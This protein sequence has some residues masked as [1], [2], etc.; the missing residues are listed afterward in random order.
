MTKEELDNEIEYIHSNRT[1]KELL[2][3]LEE[4]RKVI[5]EATN[6]Y[7]NISL[8]MNDYIRLCNDYLIDK[9]TL[10][11]AMNDLYLLALLHTG[12]E[13]KELEQWLK[14]LIV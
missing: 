10:N 12:Y 11:S 9:D 4:M 5:I 8:F 6:T 14:N 7:T 2:R 13:G 3:P 1:N